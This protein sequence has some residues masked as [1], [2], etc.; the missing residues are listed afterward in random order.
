MQQN[1]AIFQ[2]LGVPTLHATVV[3]TSNIALLLLL[4]LNRNYNYNYDTAFIQQIP[5]QLVQH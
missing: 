4:L 5:L 1:R 2:S 3:H